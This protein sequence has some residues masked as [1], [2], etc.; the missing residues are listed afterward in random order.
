MSNNPSKFVL[1]SKNLSKNFRVGTEILRVL[2]S[3][4]LK[5][6]ESSSLSIQGV[7]G[8]GR[9]TLLN[10]LARLETADDGFIYWGDRQ[11][12][13]D[14]KPHAKESRWRSLHVGVVYQSYYL[15]PELTVLENVMMSV[16]L[17]GLPFGIYE[18][19]ALSLLK[20]MGVERK[21]QQIPSKLSGGERQRVAIA[22]ALVNR[23]RVILA[24]E[25]TGN[26]DERTGGEV[27]ELLLHSCWKEQSSLVLVT[28]NPNFAKATNMVSVLKDGNLM[29]V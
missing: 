13:A 25:P 15:I 18:E 4:D 24:D 16:K 29:Y 14:Q 6:E 9:T 19:R 21:S 20:D 11:I 23:P 10:L 26:L 7:S 1:G 12:K 27:M 17:A 22:R 8:C 3:V 2:D 5:L 28:H